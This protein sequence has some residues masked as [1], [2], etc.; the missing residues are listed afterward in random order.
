ME[1]TDGSMGHSQ[2]GSQAPEGCVGTHLRQGQGLPHRPVCGIF[3][4]PPAV[5]V[6][7]VNGRLWLCSPHIPSTQTGCSFLP[8]IPPSSH[9]SEAASLPGQR[10]V[11]SL[12]LL[13]PQPLMLSSSSE[14]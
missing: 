13:T 12:T 14:P 8:C 3:P 7:V 4:C 11:T 6:Y 2:L 9:I 5:G 1:Q 10:Q